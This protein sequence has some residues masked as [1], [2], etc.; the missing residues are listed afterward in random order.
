MASHIEDDSE[1]ATGAGLPPLDSDDY[2]CDD[3][4]SPCPSPPPTNKKVAFKPFA[5]S[6]A[7]KRM[8]AEKASRE[9]LTAKGRTTSVSEDR[10]TKDTGQ[11][12]KRA[13][14]EARSD[15]F[16]GSTDLKSLIDAAKQKALTNNKPKK[17]ERV[18]KL[19]HRSLDDERLT[20]LL[21]TALRTNATPEQ[22]R[23]LQRY[24]D[25]TR[26]TKSISRDATP[27]DGTTTQPITIMSDTEEA[28]SDNEPVAAITIR[29]PKETKTKDPLATFCAT[30]LWPRYCRLPPG[31]NTSVEFKDMTSATINDRDQSVPVHPIPEAWLEEV[32]TEMSHLLQVARVD[33]RKWIEKLMAKPGHRGQDVHVLLA[34]EV[35]WATHHGPFRQRVARED[36]GVLL[37]CVGVERRGNFWFG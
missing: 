29:Q 26:T 20:A 4:S 19:Y 8:N 6:R 3:K 31:P 35:M 34:E 7:Q 23:E 9:R 27:R 10:Q 5:I 22:Q 14:E 15:K 36:I 1:T 16:H 25:G 28:Q 30:Q 17:A 24:I 37:E 18:A 21:Q 12:E 13:A 11:V 32:F 2:T 33:K